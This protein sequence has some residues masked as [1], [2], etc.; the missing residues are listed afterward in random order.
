MT[1]VIASDITSSSNMMEIAEKQ[2][3]LTVLHVCTSC[4]AQSTPR[5]PM[6]ER[7][8][9]K[10]Y[11]QLERDVQAS[12]LNQLVTVKPTKCLSLCP[13]PCAIAISSSGS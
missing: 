3:K 1:D 8:G 6:E 4:R 12:C 2:I 7:L 13:R 11:Q 9:F 5:E 10:L